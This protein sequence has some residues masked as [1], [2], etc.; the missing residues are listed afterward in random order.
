[1]MLLYMTYAPAG[2]QLTLPNDPLQAA[3]ESLVLSCK[4]PKSEPT[5]QNHSCCRTTVLT[6]LYHS[7]PALAER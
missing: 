4:P 5:L 2:V 1:M 3:H 7:R 6:E